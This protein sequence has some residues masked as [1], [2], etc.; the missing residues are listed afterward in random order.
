[1]PE[2]EEAHPPTYLPKTYLETVL[3]KAWK[4]TEGHLT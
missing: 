3:T 1:M 2:A 4:G